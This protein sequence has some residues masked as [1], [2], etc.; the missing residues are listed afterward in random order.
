MTNEIAPAKTKTHSIHCASTCLPIPLLVYL[1]LSPLSSLSYPYYCCWFRLVFCFCLCSCLC[2]ASAL[3]S[4]RTRLD[5]MYL[6]LLLL[7]R[8][9]LLLILR[10]IQLMNGSGHVFDLSCGFVQ[11]ILTCTYLALPLASVQ[12][13]MRP[14][15]D[16]CCASVLHPAL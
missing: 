12:R 4:G 15:R 2:F 3:A 11:L 1:S 6:Y 7:L 16:S 5:D 9:L 13:V 14:C 10:H 8:W